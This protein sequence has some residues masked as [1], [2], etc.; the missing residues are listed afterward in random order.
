MLHAYASEAM[1]S[2]VTLS[3]A[4][5]TLLL[6]RRQ[7]AETRGSEARRAARDAAAHAAAG[8]VIPT[9]AAAVSPGCA[10]GRASVDALASPALL[11]G[12]AGGGADMALEATDAPLAAEDQRCCGDRGANGG[13]R[14]RAAS[15]GDV[16]RGAAGSAAAAVRAVKA[17]KAAAKVNWLTAMGADAMRKRNTRHV[18]PGRDA[19]LPAGVVAS[20][21]SGKL[22]FPVLYKFHEVHFQPLH[23]CA[24]FGQLSIMYACVYAQLHLVTRLVCF[25]LLMSFDAKQRGGA[26]PS[27]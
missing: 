6:H 22:A 26:L 25:K 15:S 18:A 10:A 23:L 11:G 16:V 4:L 7:V 2:R 21:A 3:E 9:A 8:G 20:Q 17:P 14:S 5:R 19:M 13:G 24:W 1:P 12:A 27:T